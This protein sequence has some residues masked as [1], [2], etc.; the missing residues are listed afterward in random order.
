MGGRKSYP[1]R[2][3]LGSSKETKEKFKELENSFDAKEPTKVAQKTLEVFFSSKKAVSFHS[4]ATKLAPHILRNIKELR[5]KKDDIALKRDISKVW[6]QIKK[7][8][9]VSV[10]KEID[11][12]IVNNAIKTIRGGKCE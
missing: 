10:P 9:N 3:L 6:Q 2:N 11:T 4:Y 5:E 12:L 7:K 1:L 8:Q